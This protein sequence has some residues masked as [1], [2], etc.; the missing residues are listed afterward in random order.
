MGQV[1]R[2][3]DTTLGRQVAIKILPD[4][5]ASDPERLARFEREA[6]TLASLN[7]P[8]IAQIYGFEVMAADVASG[9]SRTRALVMELVEGEDLSQRIARG[10]IPLDE[11]L[12]IAKQI[13][14]AL[15]AAHEQG[16][17]HRDLKPANVKVR[18]DG[19]V[20]VLDFGLAK[21]MDQGSGIGDQGSGGA[22]N[23]P[24]ITSPAMTM[25]GMILGTAAY[26]SPE[27][28]A[29]KPVD[30]RSDLWAFGVVLLEMLTGRQVFTGES[31]SHVIASVLKSEPDWTALP[32]DTPP[33]I[34]RLL[35]RCLEKDRKRRLTDA[36]AARLEIDD[37]LT[38]PSGV[39]AV[40]A[41]ASSSAG[42]RGFWTAALAIAAAVIVA[43]AVPAV[44]HLREAA[45][46]EPRGAQFEVPS[47]TPDV[48]A[49]ALS[50][51]GRYLAMSGGVDARSQLWV[52]PI[53]SLQARALP[54]TEGAS[55]PFWSPESADI[56]FSANGK[57]KK[58]ALASGEVQVLCD[59][60]S[61]GGS[62]GPHGT[63]F[64][65]MRT[66][67]VLG[68]VSASGGIP[69]AVTTAARPGEF[70]RYPAFLPGGVHFLFLLVS[71][72]AETTGIYLGS[73]DG[74]PSVRLLPDQS[75]AVYVPANDSTRDGYL[76]FR[77]AT[78]LMALP[79][80]GER[81]EA[82]GDMFPVAQQVSLAG[83][84]AHAGFSVSA[85]G[86]LAYLPYSA[87]DQQQLVFLDRSGKRP[88]VLGK[89][90]AIEFV[91]I[92]PDGRTA[93]VSMLDPQTG[94][95]DLW[96][97]DVARNTLSRF[98][99]VTGAGSIATSAVWSPDGRR[100]AF[101][102]RPPDSSLRSLYVQA[103][104]GSGQPALQVTATDS[105]MMPYA[106][107]HDGKFVV[108]AQGTSAGTTRDIWLLP[109][110]GDRTPVPYLNTAAYEDFPQ[111]S[112]DSRWM[113]Y[114]S[115]ESGQA[116]VY[117][118]A[119]PRNGTR[120]QVSTAGGSQPR[121]RHDGRE[122]FY[123]SDDG[124]MM[125]ATI[126]MAGASIEAG[127]P[128]VLFEGAPATRQNSFQYQPTADGQGFLAIVDAGIT[129][130]LT[131]VLNWRARSGQ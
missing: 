75:N 126:Q 63:I 101:S 21:A 22:A 59:V 65:A 28:A 52:R 95:V 6:K 51:D 100:L 20:K 107:S 90:G 106:W 38:T 48:G 77:R 81:R 87:A 33:T 123:V 35:R 30:K 71:D 13:T 115:N 23:S 118:E 99:S 4:A 127:P 102:V 80:N 130:R 36:G 120:V 8:N 45:P 76:L 27:Q 31:V 89:T 10:A 15:E 44:R 18:P 92:S 112:P 7:H 32:A 97:A 66:S 2:A 129:P 43:L 19:T 72:Q 84:A 46:P 41:S 111:L 116:Q 82:I 55:Y 105:N 47:P 50:P 57:L 14:E 5:F 34:R 67:S 128:V 64:F 29:G 94:T 54:G 85:D 16:I 53:D 125:A 68:R 114:A 12:P 117:I 42:G 98:T 17:V 25:H 74:T 113:S 37:A 104:N 122:L 109:L 9:F 62:W 60:D 70:H 88:G 91:T 26:M 24:T 108:F 78:T 3:T 1:W 83:N 86:A 58:V 124:T 49:F 69:V 11:V 61:L 79:F 96:L 131:V 103:A 110:D 119:I 39:E 40:V 73:M 56:A 121:W 93:A